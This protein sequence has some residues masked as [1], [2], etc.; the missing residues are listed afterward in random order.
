MYHILSHMKHVIRR[1]KWFH[2]KR[3]VPQLYADLYENPVIQ[4]SLKTD[5]QS[6]A[7]QRASILNNE[8]E[9]LSTN[10]ARYEQVKAFRLMPQPFTIEEGELTPT[11]KIKRK[12]VEEKYVDL[13]NSMY[14]E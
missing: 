9:R 13:I 6:I 11:L 3:R 5:S 8:L 12:F 2:Y 7:T 10:L 14:E 1:G 4:V